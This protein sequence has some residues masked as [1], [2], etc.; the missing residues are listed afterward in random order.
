MP[1]AVHI[2]SERGRYAPCTMVVLA[3]ASLYLS[4]VAVLA[5]VVWQDRRRA[6]SD[7][8]RSEREARRPRTPTL[9]F[10]THV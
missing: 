10:R 6:P 3:L 2:P 8:A 4:C 9:V 5:Y 1:A 7:A